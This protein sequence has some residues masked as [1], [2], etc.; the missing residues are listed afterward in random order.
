MRATNRLLL[1]TLLLALAPGCKDKG[2]SET[3]EPE[4][5]T[6]APAEPSA[7]D[8]APATEDGAGAQAGP[9]TADVVRH[10]GAAIEL[11]IPST[12]N[13][14]REGESLMIM[15]PDET[16]LMV[17]TAVPAPD[18]NEALA[19]LDKQLSETIT[20]SE[21]SGFS[22]TQLHG[23]PALFADGKGVMDNTPVELGVAL[24][25]APDDKVLIALGL[26]QPNVT[27][28]T[29]NQLTEILRSL[30]PAQQ[31]P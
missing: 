6:S 1:I 11:E 21:V 7:E 26:A 10:P 25:L 20:D 12:W 28:E 2:E 17:F 15:S 14:E 22:E 3:P 24:V 19:V 27:P 23:M 4:G 18:L 29:G 13:Q 9:S 31:Q 30:R 8:T 5:E 16:V